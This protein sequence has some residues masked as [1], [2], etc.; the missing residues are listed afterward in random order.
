MALQATGDA[1]LVPLLAMAA[2]DPEEEAWL[3]RACEGDPRAFGWLLT[4]Y[5]DRVVRLAAH[6]LRN[7]D[8]AEDA[9]QEAFVRAFRSL[10]GYS[11]RSSFYTWLYHIAVRVCLDR[12]KLRRWTAETPLADELAGGPR[13]VAVDRLVVEALLDRLSPP[14]RAALVLREMDGLEYGEIAEVLDIPIGTVR[15]RLSAARAQFRELYQAAN[16]EA[17]RV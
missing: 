12:R 1:R 16:E 9:A 15:S 8:E 13:E 17:E 14:M 10:R 3:Q 4:R 6:V 7:P 11:G 2:C 5:R